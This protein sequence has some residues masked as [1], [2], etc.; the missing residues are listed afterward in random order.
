MDLV[1]VS[2]DAALYENMVTS[3]VAARKSGT[4]TGFVESF[5]NDGTGQ[6]SRMQPHGAFLFDSTDFEQ[7]TNGVVSVALGDGASHDPP[8]LNA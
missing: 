8:T 5:S 4:L 6:F 3:S 7:N 1:T 2:T